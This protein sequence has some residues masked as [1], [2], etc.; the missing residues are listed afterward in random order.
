MTIIL[1]LLLGVV[2]CS[3]T[4]YF[5]AFLPILILKSRGQKQSTYAAES[6]AMPQRHGP[7]GISSLQL[8]LV[9]VVSFC[10]IAIVYDHDKLRMI[11]ASV[12]MVFAYSAAAI[13]SRTQLLFDDL[14]LPILWAGLVVNSF[15]SFATLHEAVA[16]AVCAYLLMWLIASLAKLFTKRATVGRGDFK[17]MAA[18]GAW[19]GYSIVL[20][21]L[22]LAGVSFVIAAVI[23][24]SVLQKKSDSNEYAMGPFLV[25]SA[26]FIQL[27]AIEL[28][29]LKMPFVINT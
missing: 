9:C 3:L 25:L 1:V 17:F 23:R 16:G 14:V 12:F 18:I 27:V 20:P 4:V 21:T 28:L 11:L 19:F 29:A 15:G 10:V 22:W 5:A 6:V 13:D 7:S 2:S 8:L 26:M 24:K